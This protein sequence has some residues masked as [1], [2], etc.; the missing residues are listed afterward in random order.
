MSNTNAPSQDIGTLLVEIYQLEEKLGNTQELKKLKR[1]ILTYGATQETISLLESI[2]KIA[3]P[4]TGLTELKEKF[5]ESTNISLDEL[6]NIVEK[7]SLLNNSEIDLDLE[8]WAGHIDDWHLH[9]KGK[10]FFK[11]LLRVATTKR[12]EDNNFKVIKAISSAYT[13]LAIEAE[14]NV[15]SAPFFEKVGDSL[16]KSSSILHCKQK[17]LYPLVVAFLSQ[18]FFSKGDE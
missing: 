15:H 2:R 11:N 1:N 8:E 7:V 14:Q 18:L 17:E 5:L 10:P 16:L 12:L 3:D 6:P 4:I 13:H 9:C